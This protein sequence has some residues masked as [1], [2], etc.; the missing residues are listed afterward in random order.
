MKFTSLSSCLKS[1][2]GVKEKILSNAEVPWIVGGAK[3]PSV[4]S[5][6]K[7]FWSSLAFSNIAVSSV[8]PKIWS[9][10]SKEA[11]LASAIW[12]LGTVESTSFFL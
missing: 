11:F 9:I 2:P 7:A 12:T 3:A 4:K 8:V 5:N 6:P 1:S 10:T